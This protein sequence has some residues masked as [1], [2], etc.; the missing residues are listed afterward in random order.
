MLFNWFGE[1]NGKLKENFVINQNQ[2]HPQNALSIFSDTG[3]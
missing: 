3:L 1:P 2:N